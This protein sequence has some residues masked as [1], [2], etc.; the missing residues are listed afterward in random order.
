MN[1]LPAVSVGDVAWWGTQES[2]SLP[3]TTAI[4]RMGGSRTPNH[5]MS[6]DV[7]APQ[8]QCLCGF[9]AQQSSASQGAYRK[10]RCPLWGS[11]LWC[12]DKPL[13]PPVLSR[14]TRTLP[15]LSVIC[16]AGGRDHG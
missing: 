11:V 7:V 8:S 14:T 13:N 6:D 4:I 16:T 15:S 1:A 3:Y 5:V 12:Y 2:L 9:A 10:P